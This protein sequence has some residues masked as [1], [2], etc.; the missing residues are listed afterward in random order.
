MSF[1]IRPHLDRARSLIDAAGHDPHSLVY[2][3]LELRLGLERVC[4]EK[5]KL[6]L[7]YVS[8]AELKGW[9]PHKVLQ[10]LQELADPRIAEDAILLVSKED[11][12]VPPETWL[13]IGEQKGVKPKKL[14]RWWQKLSSYLHVQIPKSPADEISSYA[15]ARRLKT[16]LLKLIDELEPLCEGMDIHFGVGQHSFECKCGFVIRRVTSTLKEGMV[17]T[18]LNP[19]CEKEWRVRIGDSGEIGFEEN[20][21]PLRCRQCQRQWYF[22]EK[23]FREMRLGDCAKFDCECGKKSTVRCRL[24]YESN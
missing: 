18:C 21:I 10:A 1:H 4:Y 15:D 12:S 6:R 17:V 14:E 22:P 24:G 7:G 23:Y 19:K 2:A 16:E 8:A 5:L 11:A 9:Q 20:T 13:R 3:A